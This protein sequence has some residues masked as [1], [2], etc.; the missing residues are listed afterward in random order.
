[1]RSCSSMLSFKVFTRALSA[2]DCSTVRGFR[3]NKCNNITQEIGVKAI[4]VIIMIV[5][6]LGLLLFRFG[7]LFKSS[8][9][10]N[11]IFF[12]FDLVL[13]TLY[14]LFLSFD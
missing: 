6:L 14:L 1:M 11:F 7:L 5:K 12:Y 4:D 2:F 10:D 13:D 9:A 8:R 3:V